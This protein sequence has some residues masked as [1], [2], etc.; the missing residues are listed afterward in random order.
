ML[1][2]NAWIN[3]K[4]DDILLNVCWGKENSA[5]SSDVSARK[6]INRML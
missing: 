2:E 6:Q 4:G 5:T 3:L 1:V